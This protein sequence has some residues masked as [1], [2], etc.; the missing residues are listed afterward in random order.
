MKDF[1]IRASASGN[2]MGVKALGKTGESYCQK[3]LKERIYK[4]SD[5]IT[6]KQIEKGLIMEDQAID[7][8]AEYLDL[9]LLIKNDQWFENEYMTGTP[10]V[11]LKNLIIDVKC[12]WDCFTFP[13]FDKDIP[14]SDYYWQGQCYMNLTGVNSYALAYCLMD[15]PEYL[16]EKEFKYNNFKQDEYEDFRARYIYSD[17]PIEKRV[18]IFEFQSEDSAIE[19][20]NSRVI[21]CRNYIKSLVP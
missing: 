1:R 17:L 11:V 9:G 8:V 14:N 12:V 10:D 2:I 19:K 7:L 18:K 13:L 5:Q 3:W 21:E 16:I 6:S 20:V 4:R 15:T